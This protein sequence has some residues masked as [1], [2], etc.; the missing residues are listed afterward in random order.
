MTIAYVATSATNYCNVV[1]LS[2]SSTPNG[3]AETLK[4]NGGSSVIP[5]IASGNHIIQQFAITYFGAAR[6]VLTSVNV[7][8]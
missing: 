8:S 6:V 2:T 7:F 3:S 5:T 4:Y 1:T